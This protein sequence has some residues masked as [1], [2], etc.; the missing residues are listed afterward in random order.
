MPILK[1]AEVLVIGAGPAGIASAY[2]L[3]QAG[4]AYRVVD[5]ATVIASTWDSLYPSLRLNTTRFLSHMPG[6]KF[7]LSYGIF[8]TGKQYHAYLADFV[9]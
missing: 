4:I 6:A 9:A 8:P 7:P 1:T 3:Q 5:S 2:A